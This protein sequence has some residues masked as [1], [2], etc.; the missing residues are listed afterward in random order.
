[1]AEPAAVPVPAAASQEEVALGRAAFPVLVALS[2]ERPTLGAPRP[3]HVRRLVAAQCQHNPA[4]RV[5]VLGGV[6]WGGWWGDPP[7]GAP[8]RILEWS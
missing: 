3:H 2:Q 8:A 1:M 5:Q 7:V 4:W 6:G